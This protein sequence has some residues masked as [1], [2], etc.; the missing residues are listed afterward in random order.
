MKQKIFDQVQA[1]QSSSPNPNTQVVSHTTDD[2]LTDAMPS[3]PVNPS[4]ISTSAEDAISGLH[5]TAA[6]KRGKTGVP[7]VKLL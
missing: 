6:V 1:H 2:A 4:P 7:G 5:D 3:L